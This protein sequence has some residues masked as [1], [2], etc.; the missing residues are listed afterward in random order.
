MRILI[1]DDDP[2]YLKLFSHFMRKEMRPREIVC[3][4]SVDEAERHISNEAMDVVVSDYDMPG[5]SG[6]DL[7]DIA[8]TQ[9]NVG[10]ICMVTAHN[11]R[12]LECEALRR[13][14]MFCLDKGMGTQNI[15][16][17]IANVMEDADKLP[18]E[19][20]VIIVTMGKIVHV[21]EHML[22][23]TKY[24]YEEL[25]GS[26]W[27]T[28]IDRGCISFVRKHHERLNH[29]TI[30]KVS[31]TVHDREDEKEIQ[32]TML[33]K[34]P[35]ELNDISKLHRDHVPYYALIMQE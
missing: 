8:R 30:K 12:M 33:I 6:F 28:I 11:D 14:A 1:V 16:R 18:D 17:F 13:G 34:K 20:G 35:A 4:R 10:M 15:A 32:C 2:D 9:G 25:I 26:H 7:L 3:A 23:A 24:R 31:C 19:R 21:N 29:R 27:A 22:S 5:K